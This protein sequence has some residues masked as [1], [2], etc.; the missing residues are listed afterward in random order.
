MNFRKQKPAYDWEFIQELLERFHGLSVSD[1]ES[2]GLEN[3]LVPIEDLADQA[4]SG[5]TFDSEPS[6]FLRVI[7]FDLLE[8]RKT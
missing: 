3:M 4:A 5:I 6:D 2:A 7:D 8:D 1:Q